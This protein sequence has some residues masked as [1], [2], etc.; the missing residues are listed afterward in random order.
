VNKNK[1]IYIW[2]IVIGVLVAL[3]VN[4]YATSQTI[5]SLTSVS[6]YAGDTIT[7]NLSIPQNSG[8]S[9]ARVAVKYDDD[10]FTLTKKA[11]DTGL[12]S[13]GF[14]S[15]KLESPYI[16]SWAIDSEDED[17][18]TE[19]IVAELTF[20]VSSTAKTG[21]YE[22]E[23]IIMD[24]SVISADGKSV[25]VQ[26]I[27]SNIYVVQNPEDC[28]HSWGEWISG[29]IRTHRRT[30]ELCVES[31]SD[32]HDWDDGEVT[33]EATEDSTGVLTYTCDTCGATKTEIIPALEPDEYDITGTVTSYGDADEAVSV[34]LY[35][36][37][38]TVIDSDTTTD[39]TYTLSAPDGTYTLEVSKL[40]HVTR[41]Y[42]VTIDGDEVTQD[43]K[44]CLLGDVTGD[45]RVNSTDV[46]R[47]Y[48]HV[49]TSAPLTDEYAKACGD[50]IT[51]GNLNSTDISRL[52]A[53]V[54]TSA[55]LY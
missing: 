52:Y 33:E 42:E 30:C 9:H 12:I 23:I 1:P 17:T 49:S 41:E 50:V 4:V 7:L 47:L 11:T 38:G 2:T 13:G 19:G 15:N 20:K 34:I 35:D 18:Y 39:G 8:F 53:H 26:S 28:S 48:A 51:N 32:G 14:H 43:V 54:S 24:D 16:L 29:S 55:P 10:I 22:I 44:I 36:A 3:T 25:D 46:S 45:G 6:C 27:D 31:Q 37:D 5:V 21:K 40:N